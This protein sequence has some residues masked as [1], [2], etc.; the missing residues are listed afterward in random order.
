MRLSATSEGDRS[1]TVFSYSTKRQ[2]DAAGSQNRRYPDV[3]GLKARHGRRPGTDRQS[4]CR[5]PIQRARP[6]TQQA[7]RTETDRPHISD[8]GGK[9]PLGRDG[10][11]PDV[12]V[13]ERSGLNPE[14]TGPILRPFEILAGGRD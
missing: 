1:Q 12:K 3:E 13:L 11:D 4:L 10:G 8:Q 6:H 5:P 14:R 2:F 7:K 9:K